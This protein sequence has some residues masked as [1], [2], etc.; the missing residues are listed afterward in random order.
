MDNILLHPNDHK[1]E[2][3]WKL[4]LS[5]FDEYLSYNKI[6]NSLDLGSG[7]GDISYH[8]LQKNPTGSAICI[9][10]EQN[11]L[12]Q[13]AKRSNKIKMMNFDINQKLPFE[14]NS[15]DLVSC[16]G[17]LQYSYI[18][19]PKFTFDEMVR[20]SKK[21]IVVDFFYKFRPWHLLLKIRHPKYNPR[22]YSQKDLQKIF[23]KNNLNVVGSF[24][25]RNPFGKLFPSFG[26][27]TIFIL[28]K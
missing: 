8:L 20:V 26:R 27:T 1:R 16:I 19:S 22:R 4:I 23:K 18:K 2:E 10:V 9:D 17:T 11:L 13:A 14:D 3:D 7:R 21:Y 24:G 28:E 25:T 12:D 6:N 15:M 5:F